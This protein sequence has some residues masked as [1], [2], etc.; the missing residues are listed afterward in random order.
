MLQI[1]EIIGDSPDL[2]LFSRQIFAC[3]QD[4]PGG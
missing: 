1:Q 2:A 4:R 3:E